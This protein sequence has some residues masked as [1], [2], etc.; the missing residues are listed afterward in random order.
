MKDPGYLKNFVI[1]RPS[2]FVDGK[3][4]PATGEYRTATDNLRNAYSITR[5]EVAHFVVEG[6]LKNWEKWAGQA[7]IVSY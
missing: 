1:I 7:V 2:L 3:N 6:A 4:K 5:Q